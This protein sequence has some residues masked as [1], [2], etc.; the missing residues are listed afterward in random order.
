MGRYR[1]S[2]IAHHRNWNWDDHCR[3]GWTSHL[4][5]GSSG[6]TIAETGTGTTTVGRVG[7][8]ICAAGSS[9]STIPKL[10]LGR[11]LSDG[12]DESFV[13]P[14][15][16]VLPELPPLPVDSDEVE[17]REPNKPDDGREPSRA[18]RRSLSEKGNSHRW[19]SPTAWKGCPT[20]DRQTRPSVPVSAAPIQMAATTVVTRS[21]PREDPI[22]A[23][24]PNG[25]LGSIN[26]CHGGA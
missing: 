2:R 3:M 22:A 20:P 17:S 6:S 5:A 10:E 18:G 25:P 26:P 19:T 16:V 23:P 14:E 4:A 24:L 8:V 15:V 7:R 13:P 1:V 12:S 11:P 21:V 9:G